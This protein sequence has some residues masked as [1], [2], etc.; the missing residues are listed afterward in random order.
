MKQDKEALIQNLQAKIA[1]IYIDP[2]QLFAGFKEAYPT[3]KKKDLARILGIES[4]TL[5]DYLGAKA[6]LPSL[7]VAIKAAIV[8]NVDL[9]DVAV[10]GNSIES[11]KTLDGFD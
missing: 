7:P 1:N 6:A 11:N 5:S 4:T 10:K 2:A 8:L 9:R 3:L